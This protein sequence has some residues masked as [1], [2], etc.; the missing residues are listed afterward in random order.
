M[1]DPSKSIRIGTMVNA[2]GGTAA[3]RIAELRDLGF[4]SFEPFF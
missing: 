4:E 1:T 2:T 3:E